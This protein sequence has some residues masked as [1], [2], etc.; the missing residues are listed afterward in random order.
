MRRKASSVILGGAELGAEAGAWPGMW[1]GLGCGGGL[2]LAGL[3]VASKL[4]GQGA[5]VPLDFFGERYGE[6]KRVRMWA[7][8]SNIPSLLGVFV[9]QIMAA[10]NVFTLFGFSYPQGVVMSGLVTMTYTVARVFP[11]ISVEDY[12]LLGGWA[13]DDVVQSSHT[14]NGTASKLVGDHSVKFGVKFGAEYR[15]I[16]NHLYLPGPAAGTFGFDLGF[17]AGPDPTNP[18]PET[19]DSLASLLLGFPSSG[20]LPRTIAFDYFLDYFGGFIQDDWRVSESVVLNLGLRL[21]HETG[22]QEKNNA[23]VVGF[24]R[25]TLWPVQPVDGMTLRGGLLY[26]GVDGNP[27]EEGDPT[28]LK[29]GPRAG[30]SWSLDESTVLRGGVGLF[31]VP[32]QTTSSL[33]R[34]RGFRALTSYLATNDGGLT[35]A[36]TLTDPF[37]QGVADP[38]GASEGLLTGAGTNVEFADQFRKPAYVEKYSIEVQK[39]LSGLLVLSAGY[40]GSRSERLAIG[41]GQFPVSININQVD[42]R[43]LELG[44]ALLAPVPNPFFGDSTFGNLSQSPT[45]TRSQLLRPYPQFGALWANQVSAGRRRYDSM[46]LEAERRFRSGWGARVNY[47]WSRTEDNVAGEGNAFSNRNASIQNSYDLDAEYSRSITDIPHRLN[48]SGIVE[49]PF[50][51]TISAMGYFQSG[52]PVAVFQGFNNTGLLGDL[53]RPNVAPGVEPGHEGSTEENLGSYL[54]RA[55]WTQAP[56]FLFGNAPRTDSRVRTPSRHNFDVALQKSQRVGGG[57]LMVRVEVI[58]VFDHPD[59]SGPVTNVSSPNFGKI[60]SVGGFPRLFQFTVRYQW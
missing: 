21:E 18:D 4:R 20:E 5:Y 23:L 2:I 58:N 35:P 10:G 9:A 29:W 33:A 13:S 6:S 38:V 57:S 30:L 60:L 8:L 36:G 31:W 7:W 15:R 17:T 3:L 12:D 49:L 53:Q 42:P 14:V 52:F 43:F 45:L 56:A 54:N 40:L 16:G 48:V 11:E 28:A 59:F 50:G 24:D 51:W 39:E 19:G 22:L 41:G 37:P 46:I 47:T 26:A 27:T 1:Y 25:E 34:S 32:Y 44:S 55:A